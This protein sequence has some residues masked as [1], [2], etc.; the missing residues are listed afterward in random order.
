MNIAADGLQDTDTRCTALQTHIPP[1]QHFLCDTQAD[2][3]ALVLL[4][5]VVA[6]VYCLQLRRP[7]ILVVEFCL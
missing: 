7:G 6:A 5:P 3:H 2:T 4:R 1:Q